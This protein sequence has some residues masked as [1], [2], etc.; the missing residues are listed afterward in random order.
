MIFSQK[1][2][3]AGCAVAVFLLSRIRIMFFI[4]ICAYD[5]VIGN[6]YLFYFYLILQMLIYNFTLRLYNPGDGVEH[7]QMKGC[8]ALEAQ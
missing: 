3:A 8:L 2:G 7:L 1:D 6:K 4:A 5:F